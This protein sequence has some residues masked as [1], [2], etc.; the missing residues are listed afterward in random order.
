MIRQDPETW[1]Q[2]RWPYPRPSAIRKL[3]TWEDSEG[4][5]YAPVS[6]TDRAVLEYSG[7]GALWWVADPPH[8]LVDNLDI[9]HRV[10]Q[11]RVM[12]VV[13]DAA[14]KKKVAIVALEAV[15]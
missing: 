3:A 12:N 15:S 14:Y 13:V 9:G 1:N 4:R 6:D 10:G 11:F 8:K 7:S 2:A 5:K